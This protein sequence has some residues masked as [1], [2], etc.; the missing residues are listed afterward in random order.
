MRNRT[1]YK[2]PSN[3]VNFTLFP[4]CKQAALLAL[5]LAAFAMPCLA[6]R[7]GTGGGGAAGNRGGGTG[8]ATVP[9]YPSIYNP[10]TMPTMTQPMPDNQPI[11]KP[12]IFQDEKCLPWDVSE[13]KDTAVS[14]TRLKIPSS[15]RGEYQKACDANNKQ[16]FDEAEQH[17]HKAIDKFG[18]YSAA[19]VMLGV[20]LEEQNKGPEAREAC[21]HA[22]TSDSKYVP[23]YLCRAE[24]AS[25]DKQWEEVLN[26][27]GLAVGLNTA[28]DAYANY[29]RAMAYFNMNNIPEAKKAALQ[30]SQTDVSR[31]E[32]PLHFLLAHIYAAEGDKTDATNEL[33][34]ILKH[35]NDKQQESAVKEYLAQLESQP[36]TKPADTKSADTKSAET[37]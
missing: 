16:K 3:R 4:P 12:V 1:S 35:R 5:A 26:V 9:A 28:G 27:S 20:V 25:R 30:S 15:A 23:A 37:K 7:G 24:F 33:K 29:Y 34:L 31:N 8:V 18:D 36:D 19:W 21:S 32:T 6:Q 13:G 14:V 22:M 11:P 10:A 17:V 2:Y